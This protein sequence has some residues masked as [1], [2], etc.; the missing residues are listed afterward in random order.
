M[1]IPILKNQ[2]Q[3]IMRDTENKENGMHGVM[4]ILAEVEIQWEI[5]VK[6]K[7]FQIEL[8]RRIVIE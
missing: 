1:E 6:L 3:M 5:L 2:T 8:L 4:I 7:Y